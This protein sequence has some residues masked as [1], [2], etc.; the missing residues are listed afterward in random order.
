VRFKSGVV[1][2]HVGPEMERCWEV[3]DLAFR[4][5]TGREALVTS[6]REA[7][8]SE[9]SK[10]Y[11]R[12]GDPDRWPKNMLGSQGATDFRTWRGRWD[13]RQLPMATKVAIADEMQ[14]KLGPRWRVIVE[15]NHIHAQDNGVVGQG[16]VT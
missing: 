5:H 6:F 8:H 10:H 11:L 4:R 14:T 15:S 13:A 2:T 3:A 16:L 1:V 12:L 9:D 7:H